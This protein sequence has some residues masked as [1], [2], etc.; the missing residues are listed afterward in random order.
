METTDLNNCDREPIHIPGKI[1]DH[2]FL[3]AIDSNFTITHCS[4]NIGNFLE[5]KA[6]WMLGKSITM[7]EDLIKNTASDTFINQ[8]IKTGMTIKGFVPQNPYRVSLKEKH[9]NLIFSQSNNYFLLEFEPEFSDLHK[10]LQQILEGT[11]S[12]MLADS[13]LAQLLINTAK[14]IKNIIGYDRV[15]I[16]K[17]HDDGHGEVIAEEKNMDLKPWLGLHYPASDIPKQARELYKINLTRLISNVYESPSSI[18]SIVDPAVNPLDLTN[19]ALRAVS[20]IHIQYLKNMGVESSFSI[21]LINN[22]KLWGLVACHSYSPRFI[23]YKQRQASK[24]I[25]QILSSALSFRKNKEDEF[26]KYGLKLKVDELIKQLLRDNSLE[27][28]LCGHEVTLLNAA[29][30]TGAAFI[31]NKEIHHLGITPDDAFIHELVEW[32]HENSEASMFYTDRLPQLFPPAIAQKA[33]ASGILACRINRELKEYLLWFRSEVITTISWAG[34]PDKSMIPDKEKTLQISPRT[35]FDTWVQAVQMNSFGWKDEDI[36]SALQLKEEVNFAIIR[37]ATELRI[38]NEKLKVAYD[39]LD[40]FS[41]T[42]SHDLKNPLSFIK[43]YAQ[44]LSKDEGLEPDVQ[45]IIERILF[46]TNKMQSMIEDILSYSK[47]SQAKKEY[48]L[49]NVNQILHEIKQEQLVGAN[50]PGLQIIIEKT[51]FLY[52]DATMVMQVFSNL[53]G[54]AVKYSLK[55]NDPLVIIQG[56]EIEEGILYRISDNGIGINPH[57]IEKIFD[58]FTRS[59]AVANFEGTGVGLA[60]VKKIMQ[61]HFGKIWVESIPDR[62]STFYIIFK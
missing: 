1:Q 24:L 8:L 45:H 38:L 27:E 28:A 52:G 43:G 58:L 59:E 46:S 32:L 57:E 60:I 50:H 61:K 49:I 2:G 53:I 11:I 12:E 25:G 54:N 36:Q 47:V 40:T 34:N 29:E 3:I 14:E 41:Y 33:S 26:R 17:F 9:F 30:S 21:S 20:P 56:E 31:F 18:L 5:T 55:K 4:E 16:Y 7:P 19:V 23:N 10:D 37:K 15:M 39:E 48:S 42:I 6:E 22:E 35:S 13:D 44:I 62:G 51:P